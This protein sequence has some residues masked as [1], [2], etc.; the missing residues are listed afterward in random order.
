[1]EPAI[2]IFLIKQNLQSYSGDLLDTFVIPP[3]ELYKH[4]KSDGYI[5][6]DERGEARRA[7]RDKGF[8]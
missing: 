3:G 2:S 7:D 5:I 4:I 1:M 8:F 6:G